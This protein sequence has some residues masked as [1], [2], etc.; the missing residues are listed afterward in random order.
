MFLM[1]DG[2]GRL[3]IFF[4]NYA[5]RPRVVIF[6]S[7]FSTTRVNDDKSF[8]MKF[9]HHAPQHYVPNSVGGCFSPGINMRAHDRNEFIHKPLSCYSR[10]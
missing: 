10:S 6:Y 3:E 2:V 4:Q 7:P 1:F 5:I 9:V 8:L